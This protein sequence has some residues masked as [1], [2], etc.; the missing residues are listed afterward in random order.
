M[1]EEL[2][3]TES[4]AHSLIPY[5]SDGS[6]KARYLSYIIA[7]FSTMEAIKLSKIHLKSVHRWR[8]SDPVFVELE[9]KA[10]TSL[11]RELADHLIDIE[12]TR[13][14]RLVLAKDFEILFKD[15]SGEQ[16][17]DK[18]EDY[19]KLIRKFYTPQQFAMIR[20]IIGGNGEAKAEAFDFTRTV[21]TIRL[22]KE[23]GSARGNQL[24]ELSNTHES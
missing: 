18:E 24:S 21:L 3:A 13:N 7:G 17:T 14:F 23:Q 10:S 9:A 6:K 20:Q 1:P 15:A 2:T 19:L 5:Y 12:F 4:I 8:E 22:E 16:L 11:R